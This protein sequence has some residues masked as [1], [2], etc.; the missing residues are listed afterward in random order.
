MFAMFSDRS[1]RCGFLDLVTVRSFGIALGEWL[2]L[3]RCR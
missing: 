3:A 2:A 1:A